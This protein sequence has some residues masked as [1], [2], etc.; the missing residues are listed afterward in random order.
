MKITQANVVLT[1]ASGGIGAAIGRLLVFEGARVLLVGRSRQNI[2]RLTSELEARIP[3]RVRL[4]ALVADVTTPAGRDAIQ[5]AAEMR[6]VNVLINNA[7]VSSFGALGSLTEAG[8]T[9]SVQTNLLAPMLLTCALLPHLQKQPRALVLN[10]GS[11]LGSIGVP[12]FSTYGAGKAGLRGF[13]EALRRELADTAVGV[14]YLAPRA[15]DTPFNDAHTL[16]FNKATGSHM[17][18]PEQVAQA[19]LK[20]I[21]TEAAERYLGFGERIA[22]RVNALSPRVLDGVFARHRKALRELQP[23]LHTEGETQ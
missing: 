13:S 23:I 12:G 2:L 16:A 9:A 18:K 1:G 15:V 4:D 17:D 20:M 6:N 7:G 21:E 14:Q 11:T 10:V 19:V 5:H 8:I 3:S 22:A